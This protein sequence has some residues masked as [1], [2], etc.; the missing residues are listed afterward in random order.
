MMEVM[1]KAPKG[2]LLGRSQ[3]IEGSGS[4]VSLGTKRSALNEWKYFL[5]VEFKVLL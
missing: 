1:S 3:V 4:G 2:R 5:R